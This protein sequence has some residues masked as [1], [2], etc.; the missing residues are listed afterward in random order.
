MLKGTTLIAA[1]LGLV[2]SITLA[3]VAKAEGLI[4]GVAWA[5]FQEERWKTDEAAMNVVPF[6]MF[7]S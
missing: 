7:L 3:G 4:I 2:A 1:A 5:S 6:N